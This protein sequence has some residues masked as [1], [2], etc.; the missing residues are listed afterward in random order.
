MNCF[1][2][3]G[4]LVPTPQ[5]AAAIAQVEAQQAQTRADRLAEQLKALGVEPEA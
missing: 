4:E 5:E 2:P 1:H 3:S